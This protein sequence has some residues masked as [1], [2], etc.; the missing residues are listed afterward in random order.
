MAIEAPLSKHKKMN[1][2]IYIAV[3]ILAA[4][5]F[6]YD[7]YLSKYKWSYRRSF[8]EEH[9]KEG[10]LDD[11]MKW[12]RRLP[13]VFGAAGIAFA[14]WLGFIKDKR[15]LADEHE[16]II[17]GKEKI[18]YDAIQKIDK[19]YFDSKGYF[20]ITHKDQNGRE[21]NRK[22][23]DRNYDNLTAIL[24]YLVGKIS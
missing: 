19:T 1:Y 15:L 16:L 14:A 24:D 12:N 6:A 17:S 5:V 10:K 18:P 8:F 13:F 9:V 4:V 11:T 3:C 7:G 22:L 21:V 2:K 20:I 23:S